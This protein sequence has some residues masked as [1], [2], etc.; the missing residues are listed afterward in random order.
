MKLKKDIFSEKLKNPTENEIK[1]ASY[2]FAMFS[3]NIKR[4]MPNIPKSE[5][6]QMY[7][8]VF[9]YQ[10]LSPKEQSNRDYLIKNRIINNS[11]I[12]I[13]NINIDKPTIFATFHLGAYRL[14]NC[15]L[16]ERGHK[17]ALIIDES[18][19]MSQQEEMLRVC[20]EDLKG[21]DTSDMVILN[22]K[23]RTSIFK[24]K[25]L[26][27]KGY[28][29]TV[30]LDGNTGVNVKNQDFS[31]GYIPI[32]F[33]E[34]NIFVKNGVGKLASLLEAQ[35]IPVVSYRDENDINYMEFFKEI[36]TNDFPTKQEF[37]IKTIEIA[38]QKLEE[39]LLK[40]PT[41]WECW[42]Y[43]HKWFMRDVSTPYISTENM[44][45]YF[46][47]DRYTTFLLGEVPFLFDLF[48]YQSYPIDNELFEAISKND[49]KKI[50]SN[51]LEE[52]TQKNIIV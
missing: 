5:Y 21:K 27:E 18:V 48:D 11:S 10:N 49:F 4:F 29:M 36:Q 25:Q 15:Y 50:D 9:Y 51:L 8:D 37:S 31:K 22:V 2:S 20:R 6:T 16:Y 23:D 7:K 32:P 44:C 41:Q 1:K 28:I 14:L 40:H 30:Y 42:L 34:S 43:I 24:L 39:K 45:S 47:S 17:I 38:Y 35:F 33:L 46:N 52:L 26:I 13:D 3:A 19:F 12:D